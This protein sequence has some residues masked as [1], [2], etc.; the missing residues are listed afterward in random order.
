VERRVSDQIDL[1]IKMAFLEG[2]LKDLDDVVRETATAMRALEA[3]LASLEA[4]VAS[5]PSRGAPPD[6]VPPHWGRL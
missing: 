4:Q 3:R 2:A 6:E 5:E 1:E